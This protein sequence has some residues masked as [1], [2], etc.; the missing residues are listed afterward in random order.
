MN[1]VHGEAMTRPEWLAERIA[2][3]GRSWG[4]ETPR[5][6][7][8]LWWCMVASALVEQLA[9]AYVDGVPAPVPALDRLDCEVRPDGGVERVRVL[10]GTESADAAA[11]ALRATLE[12]VIPAVAEVSGAGVASLWAVTADAIGNRALDAGDAAAGVRLAREVG[13]KLPAPRFVEVGARTFVRRISCCLVFE[14]PGCDMC[15]SCPKRP[16][17]ERLSMLRELAGGD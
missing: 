17:E 1:S 16:A 4:T 9:R 12:A 7:G 10:P 15:T 14:A 3:M 5:V 8:T 13:G 11:P 6:A 2:E